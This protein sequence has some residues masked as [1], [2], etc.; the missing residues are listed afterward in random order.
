MLGSFRVW[1][2][3]Q[4]VPATAWQREKAR[5]LFQLLVMHSPNPLERDQFIEFLWRDADVDQG[6]R[7]FRVTLSTLLRVLVPE[8]QRED[9]SIFIAREGSLYSLRSD[10]DI[11]VDSA[12][13]ERLIVQGETQ[14]GSQNEVKLKL[15]H[16]ALKL[17]KGDFLQDNLYEEWAAN[18]R[19]RLLG[20]YLR[21]ANSLAGLF[22]EKQDWNRV[23]EWGQA[24][25]NRDSCWEEA[26]RWN[27]TAYMRLGNKPA[28]L[29]TYQ[30][31]VETLQRELGIQPSQETQ[32]LFRTIFSNPPVF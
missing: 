15:F 25:L 4:E 6:R 8:H 10:A 26:Y 32:K 17:Y 11:W 24:I 27:M 14:D 29:R 2:G 23:L 12:E 31:C 22:A 13:F 21:T 3:S 30:K 7:N 5:Q 9:D 1:R 19:E 28:A 18:E 20:L 16:Q